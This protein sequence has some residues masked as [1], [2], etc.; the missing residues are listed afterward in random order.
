MIESEAMKVVEQN[1][2]ISLKCARRYILET[3]NIV[4]EGSGRD[5]A[6][7]EEIKKAYLGK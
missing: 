6:Q 2:R 1:V 3:G 5:L 7:D 4:L